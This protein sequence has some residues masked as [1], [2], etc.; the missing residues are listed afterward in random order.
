MDIARQVREIERFV[1][2]RAAIMG[3]DFVRETARLICLQ[4]T[5]AGLGYR[6][7]MRLAEAPPC[8][9]HDAAGTGTGVRPLALAEPDPDG[10]GDDAA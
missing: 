3:P 8:I 1:P 5:P 2:H 9:A 10:G 6:E 4:S 7:S